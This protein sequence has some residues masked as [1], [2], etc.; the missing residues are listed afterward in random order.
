MENCFICKKHKGE[1]NASDFKIYEDQA[2]AIYHLDPGEGE[3]YLGYVFIEVKRHI[4]G[5]A[6]MNDEESCAVG[7]M[8]KR[9]SA[10]YMKEFPVEHVYSF[11][12]GHNIP[13][14]HFHIVPR[15]KGSPREYWGVKVDEWPEAPRGNREAVLKFCSKLS[16][17]IN[18]E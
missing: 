11:V 8:M 6:D 14:L 17:L 9:T 10:V 1:N 15:Y 12:I 7:R 18:A 5:L 3:V 2:V 16:A 4:P 13:H